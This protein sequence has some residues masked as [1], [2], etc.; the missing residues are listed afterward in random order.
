MV[1]A[2]TDPR[3]P[4]RGGQV[5]FGEAVA[6]K[7]QGGRREGLLLLEALRRRENT[8]GVPEV[9]SQDGPPTLTYGS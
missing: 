8:P 1:L 4:C 7:G 3:C 2:Q 5:G 6:Y 9:R